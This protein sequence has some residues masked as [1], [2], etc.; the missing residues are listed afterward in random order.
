MRHPKH[1]AFICCLISGLVPFTA[2][3]E[4]V[5]TTAPSQEGVGGGPVKPQQPAVKREPLTQPREQVTE[6]RKPIEKPRE[7]RK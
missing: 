6:P 4:E 2:L 1:L 3:A 7:P 5:P